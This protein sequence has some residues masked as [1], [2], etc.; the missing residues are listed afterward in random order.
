MSVLI[1][2]LSAQAQP[3]RL[4][5]ADPAG[6]FVDGLIRRSLSHRAVHHPYLKALGEGAVPDLRWALADFARQYLPY[7][8]SFPRYLTAVISRLDDPEHRSGLIENLTEESGIYE[9]EEIDELAAIGVRPEW[10]VG[11]PHPAL[12]ARFGE[13][14]GV[15][16]PST[17]H[18]PICWRDLFLAVLVNGSPAEAVGAL[19]L[20]TETI[21]STMYKPF[22]AAIAQL[23]DID[24]ADAVFFPLHTAVDD[25]HQETLREIAVDHARTP[26]GRRGLQHGMLKALQL[27]CAFWDWMYERAMDPQNAEFGGSQWIA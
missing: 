18:E 12:F 15:S 21:V 8:Q 9:Q 26:E 2:T 3:Q 25:H 4:P 19:G 1:D 20:G 23:G 16:E 14:M 7:S 10:I 5:D 22:V 13:A 17:E 27:R 11:V 24:G 6:S